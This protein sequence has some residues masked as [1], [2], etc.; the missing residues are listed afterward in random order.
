MPIMKTLCKIIYAAVVDDS[1]AMNNLHLS[2]FYDTRLAW[3]QANG[4][5]LHWRYFICIFYKILQFYNHTQLRLPSQRMLWASHFYC[6]KRATWRWQI[7]VSCSLVIPLQTSGFSFVHSSILS[8]KLT[9]LRFKKCS[10]HV[11]YQAAVLS[12]AAHF[13]C[14]CLHIAFD[15]EHHKLHDL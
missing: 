6:S 14:R 3:P 12:P 15:D 5:S 9:L 2:A 1:S 7:D 4:L 10:R 11:I 13:C 8:I